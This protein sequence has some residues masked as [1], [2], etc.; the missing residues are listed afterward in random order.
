VRRGATGSRRGGSAA[1]VVLALAFAAPARALVAQPGP[2]ARPRLQPELRADFIAARAEAA[3]LGAGLAVPAGTYVRLA[4]IG[5][6]G[7]AWTD[8]GSQVAGRVD[9]LVRFVADPLRESR[10]APYASGGVGALFDETERW[11]AVLVGA[12]GLEGPA[13]G[14]VAP[15]VEI[16]FGG[17]V[18]I[19]I[20][21][22]RAFPGR[23]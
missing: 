4:L 9:G 20:A 23:R 12:L 22:R 17:G 3:H 11:R 6:A 2:E 16:G 13:S 10:W 21:L 15:A 18:R 8:G 14:G 1:C 5:A 19:G 7:R